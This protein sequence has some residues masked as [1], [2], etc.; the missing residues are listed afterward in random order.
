MP[1]LP[2]TARTPYFL[3]TSAWYGSSRM[4]VV[5]P[6]G[7]HLPLLAFLHHHRSAMV[8]YRAI[9]IHRR[10][11]FHQVRVHRIAPRCTCRRRSAPH[12]PPS[13]RGPSSSVSWSA[14]APLRRP[15][16]RE[17]FRLVPYFRALRSGSRYSHSG[18][19][20][21][22]CIQIHAQPPKCPAVICNGNEESWPADGSPPSLCSQLTKP[23]R[24]NP[25]R[26]TPIRFASSMTSASSFASSGTGFRSSSVRNN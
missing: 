10:R 11:V 24:Q 22:N 19:R 6:C 2:I 20:P 16:K 13:T 23:H 9:Q 26:P 14:S 8:K 21:G 15:V 18:N 3:I 4:L 5:G 12:R 17:A 25:S 1:P 7:F